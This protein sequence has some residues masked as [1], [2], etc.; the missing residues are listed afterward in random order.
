MSIK[1]RYLLP[2]LAIG[3]LSAVFAVSTG[4]H[5]MERIAER[6]GLSEAQQQ[7]LTSLRAEF[8]TARDA[9]QDQR[10]EVI[11]LVKSGNVDA[12][13]DLAAI[14]ARDRVYQRAEMRRRMAEILSPEQLAQ[15][16]EIRSSRF[17]KKGWHP[18]RRHRR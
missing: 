5:P 4:A 7:S 14:Q 18:G 3:F 13:A 15:M 12:A 6:L 11:A 16:E 2:F 17:D 10:E 8:A 9:A 1:N